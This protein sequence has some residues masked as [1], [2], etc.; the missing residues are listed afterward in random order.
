LVSTD[1][2]QIQQILT[3]FNSTTA[4]VQHLLGL[5]VPGFSNAIPFWTWKPQ[6]FTFQNWSRLC[7][8][9]KRP[10]HQDPLWSRLPWRWNMLGI[11]TDCLGLRSHTLL[12]FPGLVEE[13]FDQESF[14]MLCPPWLSL[15][16]QGS[17]SAQEWWW[18]ELK[19]WLLWSEGSKSSPRKGL[20]GMGMIGIAWNCWLRHFT[21]TSEFVSKSDGRSMNLVRAS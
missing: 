21:S 2:A 9:Q 5:L 7:V 18:A 17:P 20:M 4:L 1:S 13:L 11:G 8:L 19:P 14:S 3:D 16:L 15:T 12:P 6:H 10:P